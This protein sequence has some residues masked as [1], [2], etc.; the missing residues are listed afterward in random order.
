MADMFQK[1]VE[2]MHKEIVLN[3]TSPGQCIWFRCQYM[4]VDVL[5]DGRK[6]MRP[7]LP[8]SDFAQAA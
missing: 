8:P 5:D 3:H 1:L 6:I 2:N 7:C 4:R